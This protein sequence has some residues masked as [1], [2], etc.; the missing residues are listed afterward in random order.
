MAQTIDFDVPKGM[1]PQDVAKAFNAYIQ[2]HLTF[3]GSRGQT[4]KF[5]SG[6]FDKERHGEINWQL[7]I[8]GDYWLHIFPGGT[9]AT[10][11]CRHPKQVAILKAMVQLFSACYSLT[12]EANSK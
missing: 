1:N 2:G 5:Y 9:R 7:D 8:T 4:D 10:I 3:Q 11:S 12:S 6:P